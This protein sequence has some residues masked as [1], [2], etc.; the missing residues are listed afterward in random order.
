M[1]SFFRRIRHRIIVK[2]LAIPENAAILDTS[3]QDG[4]FLSALIKN[5]NGK[6][7]KVYGVD[8]IGADIEKAKKLIP[9]GFFEI[10]D[11]ASLPFP[12]QTFDIVISSFTL[13]HMANPIS[14]I[15]EMARVVK[16]GGII[17]L[18]DIIAENKIFNFILK[19]MKCPEP[20]HFEKYYSF[21]EIKNLLSK[22]GLTIDKK[23]K[24]AAFPSFT[25]FTPISILELSQK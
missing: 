21:E 18:I 15:K 14:S 4:G 19:R 22:T 10:T 1:K 3:C 2:E 24:A 25:I 23:I 8:L 9:K 7:L 5:S 6:N 17:Y 20:Y 12:D 13:H 11:N 16:N